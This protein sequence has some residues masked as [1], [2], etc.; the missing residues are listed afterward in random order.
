MSICLCLALDILGFFSLVGSV[1][2]AWLLPPAGSYLSPL[3][4]LGVFG[5]W[6]RGGGGISNTHPL[7]PV[8]LPMPRS[9]DDSSSG[10]SRSGVQCDVMQCGYARENHS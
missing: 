1:L 7:G 6:S 5:G 2:F 9:S 8:R 10:G 3:F 4:I